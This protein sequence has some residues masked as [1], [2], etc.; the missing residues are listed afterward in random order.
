MLFIYWLEDSP[1]FGKEVEH[2]RH[3][4][5]QR[6]DQ[7]CTAIFTLGEVLTGP[8][9]R[10]PQIARKLRDYF[11]SDHV[12]LL[13]FTSEAADRYGRIRAQYG[14]SPADAIHL[15]TASVAQVDL[16]LTNDARLKELLIEGIQFIAGLD[17]SVL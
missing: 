12:R 2:I 6:G 14:V 1:Q 8:Y 5:L 3:R 13:E 4:M 11:E 10:H 16:Y 7:L 17:G 15:A 9:K